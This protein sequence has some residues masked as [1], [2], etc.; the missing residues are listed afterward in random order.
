MSILEICQWIQGWG[1]STALRE[2]IFA[3]P[4]IEGM[5][6]LGLAAIMGPVLMFDFRLAGIAWTDQ[7]VS[8]I[9]KNFVPFSIAGAILMFVTGILL[10][11]AE[12][13]RCWQSGWFR[14]KIV[15]LVVAG[16]NALYFHFKTQSSWSKWDDLRVPPPQARWAGILSMFFWGIVILAGRWTA[17]TL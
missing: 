13:V 5:H 11:C 16:A 8:R 12:P 6:L 3:F 9:A 7:P 1:W 10:F 4:V 15:L 17:Y 2:S 14:I